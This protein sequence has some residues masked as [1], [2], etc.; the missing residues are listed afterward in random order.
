MIKEQVTRTLSKQ[1]TWTTKQCICKAD[2]GKLS[3]YSKIV[4]QNEYELQHYLKLPLKK[5]TDLS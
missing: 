1:N 3:F 2:S 5:V 4:N